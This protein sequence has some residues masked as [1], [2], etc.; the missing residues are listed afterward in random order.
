MDL[1]TAS[2]LW[3]VRQE[4]RI[5]LHALSHPEFLEFSRSCQ[6]LFAEI[7][8]AYT[9]DYFWRRYG[10]ALR[11][12]RF[13]LAANPIPFD[14]AS[15]GASGVLRGFR[16]GLRRRKKVYPD[17]AQDALALV[18]AAELLVTSKEGPLLEYLYLNEL[19][20]ASGNERVGLVVRES[21]YLPSLT[22]EFLA[23]DVNA[24]S[25]LTPTRLKGES[26]DRLIF[27]GPTA[28]FPD[29]VVA[30]P[31]APSL[32]FVHFDWLGPD[33]PPR[34]LRPDPGEGTW[35]AQGFSNP[36][37]SSTASTDRPGQPILDI[38][39][40]IDWNLILDQLEGLPAQGNGESGIVPARLCGLEEGVS[41][42][43]RGHDGAETSVLS[44]DQ[45]QADVN[46]V[47]VAE[48]EPGDFLLLRTSGG[49]DHVA[50]LAWTYLGEKAQEIRTAQADW[51]QKLSD[52]I[53]ARGV[54][55]VSRETTANGAKAASTGNILA[56]ASEERIQPGAKE[57]FIALLK[58]LDLGDNADMYWRYGRAIVRARIRA[59]FHIRKLLL[60]QV[61]NADIKR[62]EELGRTDFRL[63]S[64]HGGTM[65]AIRLNGLAPFVVDVPAHRI[66]ILFAAPEL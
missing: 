29:H 26:F 19:L 65:T 33:R 10:S 41:V 39:P 57:D 5:E 53:R 61:R 4:V 64:R 54:E 56:W 12:I 24:V 46:W 1:S 55:R 16:D 25:T 49:G 23:L 63:P 30:S 59:G 20:E 48:L 35:E 43:L 22:D 52:S 27:I 8:A 18:N 34:P 14:T 51:K 66:G 2:N 38:V 50:D 58:T 28:W 9:D 47:P 15:A 3:R 40:R 21:R 44:I 32:G 6:R 17:I 42:F 13:D 62:L 37:S 11:R 7:E 36:Y 31:R 45:K 60:Q